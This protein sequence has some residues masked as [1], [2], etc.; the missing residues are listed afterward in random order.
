[1]ATSLVADQPGV[2]SWNINIH[3]YIEIM[4][5]LQLRCADA[6]S[7]MSFTYRDG[8]PFPHGFSTNSWQ[9]ADAA[10]AT[11]LGDALAVALRSERGGF[12][13]HRTSREAKI[14]W[15]KLRTL[16][17]FLAACGGFSVA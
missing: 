10:S 3:G 13:P 16:Q 8:Q 5:Y 15:D 17:Q 4:G 7:A 9:H 14:L 2:P 1:M 12:F 6:M 11:R